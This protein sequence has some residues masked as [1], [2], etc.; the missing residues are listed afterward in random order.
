M[1]I[2]GIACMISALMGFSPIAK[3]LR[4]ALVDS[5]LVCLDIQRYTQALERSE[6]VDR[7]IWEALFD[8]CIK[9]AVGLMAWRENLEVRPYYCEGI[10][11]LCGMF[12]SGVLVFDESREFGKLDI[13]RARY[14]NLA[15]WYVRTYLDLAAHYRDKKDAKLWLER[16]CINE[17][18]KGVSVLCPRTSALVEHYFARYVAIGQEIYWQSPQI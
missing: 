12:E 13:N 15:L 7:Q 3:I 1:R 8:D 18:S 2:S 5:E 10:I 6:E 11:H 16:F 9:R 4:D 17:Q 14:V